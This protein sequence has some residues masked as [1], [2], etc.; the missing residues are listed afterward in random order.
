MSIYK[1]I[2]DSKN[3]KDAFECII[4][5]VTEKPYTVWETDVGTVGCRKEAVLQDMTAVKKIISQRHWSSVR[6]RRIVHHSRLS[7]VEGFGLHGNRQTCCLTL[8]RSPVCVCLA[9]GYPHKTYSL[10]V[11]HYQLQRRQTFQ[12]GTA[13]SQSGEIIY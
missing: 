9:Q 1:R 11:E 6:T 8:H 3:D 10:R 5:Y 4:T 7:N 13:W 2:N 12:H